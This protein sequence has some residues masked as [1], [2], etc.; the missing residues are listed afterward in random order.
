MVMARLEKS[1]LTSTITNGIKGKR[2][3][4]NAEGALNN[5]RQIAKKMLIKKN[6]ICI[7]H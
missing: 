5:G 3:G 2:G 7:Q 4:D 1:L 6:R